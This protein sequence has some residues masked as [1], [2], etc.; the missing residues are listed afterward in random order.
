L[1]GAKNY[2]VW[3]IKMMDILTKQG[4]YGIVTGKETC[5]DDFELK[6]TWEKEHRTALS[7]IQLQ[8]ADKMLVYVAS[9]TSLKAAWETLKDMLEP[10]GALGK[11]L[12]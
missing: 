2:A 7:M 8:V 3:K 9:A 4:V 5:L 10:Q 6:K 12:I 1:K 11:V